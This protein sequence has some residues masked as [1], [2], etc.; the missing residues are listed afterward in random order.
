MTEIIVYLIGMFIVV[1]LIFHLFESFR[2]WA[3][4]DEIENRY[5]CSM[6]ELDEK[7]KKYNQLIDDDDEDY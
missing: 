2:E 7:L 1:P 5:G 4:R 6:E 3:A